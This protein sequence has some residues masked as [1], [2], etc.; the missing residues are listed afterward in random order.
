M[1]LYVDDVN[2]KR[3]EQIAVN[4]LQ[5]HHSVLNTN[6]SIANETWLVEA[7]TSLFNRSV[8]KLRIDA[9]TEKIIS[10]E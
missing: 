4:C 6:V 2:A 9:K 3:V 8:K 10:I 5:Q 7:R 1:T